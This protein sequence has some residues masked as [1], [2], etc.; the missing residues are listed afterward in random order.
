MMYLLAKTYVTLI[1][2]QLCSYI[3]KSNHAQT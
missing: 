1:L 2:V 3:I